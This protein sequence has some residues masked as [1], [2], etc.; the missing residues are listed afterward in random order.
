MNDPNTGEKIAGAVWSYIVG[1]S[2]TD[3]IFFYHYLV[4]GQLNSEISVIH[5]CHFGRNDDLINPF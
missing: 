2:Q 3:L 5:G 4:K 1:K